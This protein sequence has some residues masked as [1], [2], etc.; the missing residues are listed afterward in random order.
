MILACHIIT[1]PHKKVGERGKRGYNR[2]SRDRWW[3]TK[4]ERRQREAGGGKEKRRESS[5][6]KER[7]EH[8]NA[9]GMKVWQRKRKQKN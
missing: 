7:K 6:D 4:S 9:Q 8:E 5:E 1:D 2:E 3:G